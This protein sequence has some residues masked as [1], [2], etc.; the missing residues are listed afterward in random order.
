MSWIGQS[1]RRVE[2]DRLLKGQAKFVADAKVPGTLEAVFVRTPHAHA[3]MAGIDALVPRLPGAVSGM[4][5]DGQR[6]SY[7]GRSR[8]SRTFEAR[9]EKVKGF[10]RISSALPESV[11]RLMAF[12]A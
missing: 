6:R 2:D 1:V 3:S 5:A 10:V 4:G 7:K 8:T 12:S 11:L 9:L